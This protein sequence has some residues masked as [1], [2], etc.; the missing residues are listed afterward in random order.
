VR[1]DRR[2]FAVWY[3]SPSTPAFALDE[4]GTSTLAVRREVHAMGSLADYV[5]RLARDKDEAEKFS[6]SK[7]AARERMQAAGLSE[8]HQE[9]LLGCDPDEIT[10]AITDEIGHTAGRAYH[11]TELKVTF[12]IP[13]PPK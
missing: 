3:F 5:L 7:E 9:V 2:K 4:N 10:D 8:E 12:K 13:C 1:H 6:R 11:N